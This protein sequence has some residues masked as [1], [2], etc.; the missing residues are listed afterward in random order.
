MP[1]A[2]FARRGQLKILPE[3]K[4]VVE[5]R[6]VVREQG[7]S[8]QSE[9]GG[10]RQP[11]TPPRFPGAR[12]TPHQQPQGWQKQECSEENWRTRS[13]RQPEKKPREAEGRE[14][15]T[16]VHRGVHRQQSRAKL[17]NQFR[18]CVGDRVITEV[19]PA[20]FATLPPLLAALRRRPRHHRGWSR[21]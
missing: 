13:D 14:R 1:V 5:T 3:F 7:G 8:A 4:R 10:R 16:P 21:S 19:G 9:A 15:T 2:E 11:V 17:P 20:A 12:L 18:S 6:I